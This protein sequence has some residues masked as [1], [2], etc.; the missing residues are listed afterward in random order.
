MRIWFTGNLG[1]VFS[2]YNLPLGTNLC[3]LILK[4]YVISANQKPI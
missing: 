4:I 2:V 3:N 1:Q